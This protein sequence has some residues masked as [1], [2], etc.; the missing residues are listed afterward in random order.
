MRL[1]DFA[2]GGV[3]CAPWALERRGRRV[4]FDTQRVPGMSRFVPFGTIREGGAID[5]T[6]ALVLYTLL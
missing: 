2:V 4:R 1:E 6:L 5:S 3:A